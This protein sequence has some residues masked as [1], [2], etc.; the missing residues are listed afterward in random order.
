MSHPN[1]SPEINRNIEQSEKD[2]GIWAKD[3]PEGCGIEVQTQ[4]TLYEF[5]KH[6]TNNNF[7]QVKGHARYCPTWTDCRI[8]GSTWGGSMIKTG[9][10]GVGMHLEIILLS[11][12]TELYQGTMTTTRI[13]ECWIKS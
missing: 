6:P 9:F 5:R 1:L 3:V 2:G 7:W 11:S 4:N 8:V 12:G 10:I 13:K